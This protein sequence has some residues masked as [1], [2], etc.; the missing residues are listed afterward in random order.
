MLCEIK[1]SNI[2]RIKQI[3][4][5][6]TKRTTMVII[7]YFREKANGLVDFMSNTQHME[8]ARIKRECW[9]STDW[10]DS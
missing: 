9:G 4:S 6:F 2:D 1:L 5:K 3:G 8:D 7:V 10:R